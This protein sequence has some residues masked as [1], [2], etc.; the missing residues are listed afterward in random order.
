MEEEYCLKVLSS[1]VSSA[2]VEIGTI[3]VLI[4]PSNSFGYILEEELM[5]SRNF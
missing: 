5:S 3:G 4:G 2:V 1:G